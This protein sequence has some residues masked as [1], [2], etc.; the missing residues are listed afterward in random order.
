[1][2][3][4]SASSAVIVGGWSSSTDIVEATSTPILIHYDSI[5]GSV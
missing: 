5:D 3:Y 4:D 1:M 2:D